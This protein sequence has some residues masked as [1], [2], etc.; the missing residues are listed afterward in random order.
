ME[1]KHSAAF[2]KSRKIILTCISKNKKHVP[3]RSLKPHTGG[4]CKFNCAE[5][6]PENIRQEFSIH[7]MG[8]IYPMKERVT[9]FVDTLWF[10]ILANDTLNKTSFCYKGTGSFLYP[11]Q[12]IISQT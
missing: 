6:V 12:H 11:I 10:N 8:K 5:K 1:E 7:F 9:L 2:K 3:T 4:M